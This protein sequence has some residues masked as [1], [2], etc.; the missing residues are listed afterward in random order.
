VA[1]EE[2]V[3]LETQSRSLEVAEFGFRN[4]GASVQPLARVLIGSRAEVQ[5]KH[6]QKYTSGW[7]PKGTSGESFWHLSVLCC[8]SIFGKPRSNMNLRFRHGR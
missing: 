8:S 4:T 6:Y 7:I 5:P 1:T 3:F 2:A